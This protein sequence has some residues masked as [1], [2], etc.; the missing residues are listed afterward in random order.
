MFEHILVVINPFGQARFYAKI[1]QGNP[2]GA[3]WR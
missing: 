3:R 1:C 2:S